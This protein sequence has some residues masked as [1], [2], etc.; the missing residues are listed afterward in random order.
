MFETKWSAEAEVEL[1]RLWELGY[2]VREI[3]RRMDVS[4][5]AVIGK[6][7]RMKLEK[8]ETPIKPPNPNSKR[9]SKAKPKPAP[10]APIERVLYG[11][12]QFLSGEKRGPHWTDQDKCLAPTI[13]GTYCSE[14]WK[15]THSGEVLL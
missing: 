12:C 4:R 3:G 2:S 11:K 7:H 6:A 8:R 13:N 9:P 1:R 15:L 5:N 10:A 14:H